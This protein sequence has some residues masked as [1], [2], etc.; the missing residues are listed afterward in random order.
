MILIVI[1]DTYGNVD[2]DNDNNIDGE[3]KDNSGDGDDE[4]VLLNE[5]M[6]R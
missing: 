4:N 5:Y 2:E 1:D 6:N 3:E